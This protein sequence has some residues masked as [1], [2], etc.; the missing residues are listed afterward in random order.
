MGTEVDDLAI[1]EPDG[2]E[3]WQLH[4]ALPGG[5]KEGAVGLV[6]GAGGNV[7]QPRQ[8]AVVALLKI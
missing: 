7:A 1:A 2:Q 8:L 3:A 4:L 5:L 6:P